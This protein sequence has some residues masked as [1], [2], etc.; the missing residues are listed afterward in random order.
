MGSDIRI[1]FAN[2]VIDSGGFEGLRSGL[3]AEVS[4][5]VEKRP[6]AVKIPIPALRWVD[7][8]AF[9]AVTTPTNQA[10]WRWQA[11]ELGLMNENYAEVI[12]GLKVGEKVVA[13]PED[14]PAPV[15]PT[16]PVLQ[17]GGADAKPQG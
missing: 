13:R 9:A 2:V 14:L 6:D 17:A 4:F 11:L 1:Y 16:A 3:S 5:F 12:K 8:V 7:G 15:L 10:E